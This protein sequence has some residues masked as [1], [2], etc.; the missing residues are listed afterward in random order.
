VVVEILERLHQQLLVD[1]RI[2]LY[3]FPV[4]EASQVRLPKPVLV[5]QYQPPRSLAQTIITTLLPYDIV[6]V[7]LFIHGI[8]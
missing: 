8:K 3:G 1:R 5:Y 7:V 2:T 6:Y 4:I